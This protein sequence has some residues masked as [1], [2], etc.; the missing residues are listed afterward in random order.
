MKKVPLN[1][2]TLKMFSP[3]QAHLVFVH[4][5]LSYRTTSLDTMSVNR[6]TMFIAAA[7]LT[8][9]L[10]PCYGRNIEKL[11]SLLHYIYKGNYCRTKAGVGTPRHVSNIPPHLY[12]A[13]FQ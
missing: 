9:L 2:E 11:L 6:N 1:T 3:F 10:L 5:T 4:T 8:L 7:T 13:Y 12:S